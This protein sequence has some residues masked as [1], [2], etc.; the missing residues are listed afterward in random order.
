MAGGGLRCKLGL[1]AWDYIYGSQ[2][3]GGY[4]EV[5][6]VVGYYCIRCGVESSV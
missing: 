3:I 6:Y 1:H 4:G 5:R 2:T